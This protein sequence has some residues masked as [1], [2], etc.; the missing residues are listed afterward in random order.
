MKHI[1]HSYLTSHYEEK[2]FF[3]EGNLRDMH[4]GLELEVGKH[5]SV[6][7]QE[8]RYWRSIERNWPTRGVEVRIHEWLHKMYNEVGQNFCFKAFHLVRVLLISFLSCFFFY[9]PLILITNYLLNLFCE[10][11]THFGIILSFSV[12]KRS[13]SI[14]LD[15]AE[16]NSSPGAVAQKSYFFYSRNKEERHASVCE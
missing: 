16:K 6:A 5:I 4:R 15:A 8:E 9:I 10:G 13:L 7:S 12:V 14:T 2:G 3:W 11:I 1:Q